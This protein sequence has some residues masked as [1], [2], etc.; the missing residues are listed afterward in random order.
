[1]FFL[2]GGF[3]TDLATAGVVFHAARFFGG[4][5]FLVLGGAGAGQ[6]QRLTAGFGLSGRQAQRWAWGSRR[7]TGAW[8]LTL[9]GAGGAMG[10]GRCIGLGN[11][12]RALLD[13]DRRARRTT[14]HA[15]TVAQA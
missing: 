15:R 4:K 10:R 8:T 7:A 6:G 14:R 2:T 12:A 5:A 3:L 9:R 11:Q 13:D 1:F